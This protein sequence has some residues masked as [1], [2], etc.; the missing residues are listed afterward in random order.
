[1]P[2]GNWIFKKKISPDIIVFLDADY[3]DF[4]D[5]L[6]LIIDPIIN[7]NYDFVIGS[8]ILGNSEAGA[9]LPQAVIGNKISAYLI[10][11]LFGLNYTDSGPFRAIKFKKLLQM[12]MRDRTFGWNVEMQV[13]AVLHNLRIKEVPVSYRKRIGISKITGTFTG[14]VLAGIKII[15]TILKLHYINRFSNPAYKKC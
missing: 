3:S 7:H 8:R 13:K 10:K 9:I 2:E 11:K 5:E 12:D 6:N 4:P 1:M 15:Y 14:T